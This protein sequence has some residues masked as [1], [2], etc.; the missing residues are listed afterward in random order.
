MSSLRMCIVLTSRRSYA[1]ARYALNHL[2]GQADDA[3]EAAVAQLAGHRAEDARAARVLLSIDDHHGIAVEADVA[4]VVA[5]SRLLGPHD[6][7]LNDFAGL[8]FAAR[9]RLLD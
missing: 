4:A 2:G 1:D 5:A 3:G 8:H 7:A 9:Q 6:H